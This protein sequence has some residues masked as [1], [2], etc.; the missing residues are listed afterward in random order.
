MVNTK[1]PRKCIGTSF[2][3]CCLFARLLAWLT[4]KL[5]TTD[6]LYDV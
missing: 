6:F 2:G 5:R 1:D 3:E 4:L